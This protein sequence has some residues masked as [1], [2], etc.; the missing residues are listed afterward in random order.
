MI[1]I[2]TIIIIKIKYCNINYMDTMNNNNNNNNKS[3]NE[4]KYIIKK[5]KEI[6]IETD[7]KLKTKK[8]QTIMK[9]I[10]YN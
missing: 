2:I 9:K 7:T 1:I 4:I 6:I 10:F 5:L 3:N 8:Q